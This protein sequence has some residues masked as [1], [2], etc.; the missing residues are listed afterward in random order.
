MIKSIPADEARKLVKAGRILV[1]D[2]RTP[3]ENA[4]ERIKKSVLIPLNELESRAEEVPRDRPI[5]VYCR[6]GSRSM[7]ASQIL[8]SHGFQKIYNLSGGISECPF[9]CLED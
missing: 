6:S 4:H 3:M 5:L 9:E 7:A 1:L 8:A 2:V